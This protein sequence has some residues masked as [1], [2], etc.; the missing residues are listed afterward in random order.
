MIPPAFLTHGK[1]SCSTLARTHF[2]EAFLP[3]PETTLTK[4]ALLRH[5]ATYMPHSV[6]TSLIRPMCVT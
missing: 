3:P 5:K 2:C 6:Q 1:S 4:R